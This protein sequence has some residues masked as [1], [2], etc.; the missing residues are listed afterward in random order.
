MHKFLGKWI[1]E[2]IAYYMHL[3]NP[4]VIK[5]LQYR[6]K[7][8]PIVYGIRCQVNGL[9]YIGSSLAPGLRFHKHLI[10]GERSNDALQAHITKYGLGK[11][12]VHIFKVVEFPS[13][14]SYAEKKTLLITQEYLNLIPVRRRYN[15]IN[16]SSSL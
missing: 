2:H 9:I 11:F 16:A 14:S 7:N 8:V 12:T 13:D 6:F 10:T 3:D 4:D 1:P 5:A 15:T